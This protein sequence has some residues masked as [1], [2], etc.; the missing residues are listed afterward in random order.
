MGQS[1]A[2]GTRGVG[3]QLSDG[4]PVQDIGEK[5]AQNSLHTELAPLPATTPAH[6]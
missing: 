2:R 4:L 5:G 6:P 1:V 3:D